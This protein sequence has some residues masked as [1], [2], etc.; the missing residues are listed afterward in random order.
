MVA[1]ASLARAVVRAPNRSR[2][3]IVRSVT[4]CWTESIARPVNDPSALLSDAG[5][6]RKMNAVLPVV[7]GYR[8][9]ASPRSEQPANIDPDGHEF[10][11]AFASRFPNPSACI[12]A[13]PW[14]GPEFSA[15]PPE[16]SFVKSTCQM[17]RAPLQ[18]GEFPVL[19][20]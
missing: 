13:R 10:P 9:P 15:F 14:I 8:S 4:S 3:D 12:S 20:Q 19:V 1:V 5:L 11:A 7:P 18:P 2:N 17:N 6:V 16:L